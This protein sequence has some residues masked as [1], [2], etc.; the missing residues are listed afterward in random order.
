VLRPPQQTPF[1][2][3]SLV[4]FPFSFLFSSLQLNLTSTDDIFLSLPAADI[5]LFLSFFFCFSLVRGINEPIVKNVEKLATE[6]PGKMWEN[7]Q[8]HPATINKNRQCHAAKT[9]THTFIYIYT[10]ISQFTRPFLLNQNS[11]T[12]FLSSTRCDEKGKGGKNSPLPIEKLCLDV[13]AG[14][15]S[16]EHKPSGC[17]LYRRVANRYR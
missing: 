10:S 15:A 14:R 13:T 6:K 2:P 4:F 9:H 8:P 17:L 5:I 1:S 11:P 12:D 16:N 3:G 7:F